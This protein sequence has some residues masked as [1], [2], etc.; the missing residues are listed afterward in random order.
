[1]TVLRMTTTPMRRKLTSTISW[2]YNPTKIID[3]S[4]YKRGIADTRKN[5][6]NYE[7]VAQEPGPEYHDAAACLKHEIF[8][9]TGERGKISFSLTE[10]LRDE[11][12][13]GR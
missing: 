12:G 9:M 1:M 7:T 13:G 8:Q 5:L 10:L 2:V 4:D 3:F 11:D 6:A